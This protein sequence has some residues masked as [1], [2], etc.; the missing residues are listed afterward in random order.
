M[1]VPK[2]MVQN[3]FKELICPKPKDL[4][5]RIGPRQ[6]LNNGSSDGSSYSEVVNFDNNKLK[7]LSRMSDEDYNLYAHE[8]RKREE[9]KM[10]SSS[11][12]DSVNV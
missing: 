4:Y 8:M 9:E 5:S 6:P 11:E 1:Y 3:E 12:E 2:K 10:K 7:M